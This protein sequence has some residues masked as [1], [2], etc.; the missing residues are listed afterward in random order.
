MNLKMVASDCQLCFYFEQN[1][2]TERLWGF[3][4]DCFFLW[5]YGAKLSSK[6][7]QKIIG[8]SAVLVCITYLGT[9]RFTTRT[10]SEFC[11][12][13]FW[14]IGSMDRSVAWTLYWMYGRIEWTN[15]EWLAASIDVS[16]A[17]FWSDWLSFY[18]RLY[19]WSYWLFCW[20]L[21]FG[22]LLEL[23]KARICA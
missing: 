12:L 14:G 1:E 18:A 7:L 11:I 15:G 10:N 9:D 2:V 21:F 19:L 20:L 4:I 3:G 6:S 22:I 8:I 13:L 5:G 17:S 23:F 16:E